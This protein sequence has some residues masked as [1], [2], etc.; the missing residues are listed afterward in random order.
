MTPDGYR[1]VIREEF[2]MTPYRPSHDG[3]TLHVTREGDYRQ[4]P[5]PEPL[6]PEEREAVIELLRRWFRLSQH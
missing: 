2:G 1:A 3:K 4:I 6:S 5:D